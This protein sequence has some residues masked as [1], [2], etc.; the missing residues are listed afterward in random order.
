M[1]TRGGILRSRPRPLLLH[2]SATGTYCIKAD[3]KF[4]IHPSGNCRRPSLWRDTRVLVT[5]TRDHGEEIAGQ[6]GLHDKSGRRMIAP[7]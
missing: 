7:G 2:S 6:L 3:R 4:T 5:R 1:I